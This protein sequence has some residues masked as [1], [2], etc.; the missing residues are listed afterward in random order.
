MRKRE[1]GRDRR[2]TQREREKME[3]GEGGGEGREKWERARGQYCRE[4]KNEFE[5]NCK[6]ME[7][8][9]QLCCYG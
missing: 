5:K 3:E 7:G 4:K 6:N 9:L 1:R 8:V 2:E